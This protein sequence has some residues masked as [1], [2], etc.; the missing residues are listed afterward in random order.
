[1]E[2]ANTNAMPLPQQVE[3]TIIDAD[4]PNPTSLLSGKDT[5]RTTNN[6]RRSLQRQTSKRL[7]NLYHVVRNELENIVIDN[8]HNTTQ[9]SILGG[10][11][12]PRAFYSLCCLRI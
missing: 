2:S 7:E 12:A 11:V 5:S 6:F 10:I 4:I 9:P 3:V 8:S 1:M